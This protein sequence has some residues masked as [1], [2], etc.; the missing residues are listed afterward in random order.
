MRKSIRKDYKG[1]AEALGIYR[2]FQREAGSKSLSE[3]KI[4]LAKYQQELKECPDNCR[5]VQSLLCDKIIKTKNLI[6]YLVEH[7]EVAE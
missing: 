2:D 1:R 4:D 5:N 3:H 7:K 6:S